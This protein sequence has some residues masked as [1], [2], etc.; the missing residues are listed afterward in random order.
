[1]LAGLAATLTTKYQKDTVE[2]QQLLP[3]KTSE[4]SK[5]SAIADVAT[6]L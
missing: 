2:K 5:F 3:S 6:Q 1:M 4:E